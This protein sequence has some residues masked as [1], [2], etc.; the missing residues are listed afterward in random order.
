MKVERLGLEYESSQLPIQAIGTIGGRG[1]YFIAKHS[2]WTFEVADDLGDFP[3]D[4][5]GN[6]VFT[7]EAR[8]AHAGEMSEDEVKRIIEGCASAFIAMAKP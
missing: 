3:S 4:T 8:Y 5:G 7:I 2:N 6:P 1:F